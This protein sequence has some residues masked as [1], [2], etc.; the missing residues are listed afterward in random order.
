MLFRD[1]QPIKNK[2]L[3]LFFKYSI[4]LSDVRPGLLSRAFHG[5]G[6]ES[7]AQIRNDGLTHI[8]SSESLLNLEPL[9]RSIVNSSKASPNKKERNIESGETRRKKE[10]RERERERELIKP[11]DGWGSNLLL[12]SHL[13]NYTG[14]YLT[15]LFHIKLYLSVFSI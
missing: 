11:S 14:L 13:V 5:H 15:Q 2:K 7:Q 4:F 1:F 3:E 6:Q 9:F 10:E 12:K 8:R